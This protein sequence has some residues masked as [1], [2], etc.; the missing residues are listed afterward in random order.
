M[1]VEEIM[2]IVQALDPGAALSFSVYT[3]QWYLHADV[4]IG[5]GAFLTGV[6][7]HRPSPDLAVRSFFDRITDLSLGEYVV[8]DFHGHRR[9]WRWNGAAFAECTRDEVFERE[10]ERMGALS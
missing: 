1:T 10:A 4:H 9:E 6:S 2:L 7:E 8:S 5:D 3:G